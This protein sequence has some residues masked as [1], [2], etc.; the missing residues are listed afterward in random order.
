MTKKPRAGTRMLLAAPA[1]ACGSA[2]PFWPLFS[3]CGG[4][5]RP[6]ESRSPASECELAARRTIKPGGIRALALS[7]TASKPLSQ[8]CGY[9]PGAR[10]DRCLVRNLTRAFSKNQSE[11]LPACW[12][13]PLSYTPPSLGPVSS[14]SC[15]YLDK[16]SDSIVS[17][18]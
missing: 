7:L 12:E 9:S 18:A 8:D 14:A 16:R 11:H 15:R 4:F 13:D 1:V 3:P 10:F 17:A 6:S 2:P 5:G